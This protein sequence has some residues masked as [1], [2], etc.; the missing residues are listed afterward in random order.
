MNLTSTSD[1]QQIFRIKNGQENTDTSAVVSAEE[2]AWLLTHLRAVVAA[3]TAAWAGRGM[4]LL[5]LAALHII[6]ALAPV[7]L[8]GLAQELGS[9]PPATSAMVGRLTRAGLVHQ[10]PDPQDHRR[11]QL[12][13]TDR[14]QQMIGRI[15][16]STARRVQQLLNAIGPQGGRY[17]ICVLRDTVRLSAGQPKKNSSRGQGLIKRSS[18]P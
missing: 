15:D 4:T 2:I 16:S 8:T 5:Q 9:G 1:D 6:S 7:T 13:I 3:D 11:I 14:A 12:T 18:D 10:A 17:L